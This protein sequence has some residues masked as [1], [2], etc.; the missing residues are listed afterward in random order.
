VIIATVGQSGGTDRLLIGRS[1]EWARARQALREGRSSVVFS[2]SPGVGKS[3]LAHA[4]ADDL[5]HREGAHCVAIFG[6]PAEPPIPFG[7]LAPLAG[8]IGVKP[9]RPPDPLHLM[10]TFRA[11]LLPLASGRPLVMIVDDAH[12]LD[13]HS[14]DLLLQLA[15]HDGVRI[16]AAIQSGHPV[17]A[18]VRSLW[19]EEIAE[20][21][22]VSPLDQES[23]AELVTSILTTKPGGPADPGQPTEI[24]V[25]GLTRTVGGEIPEAVWRL[26]QGNPLYTRE[27]LHTGRTSG[28]IVLRDG[29]WR[30]DRPLEVGER[31]A[32]L[33]EDRW[34]SH[35]GQAER[36][37]LE[38]I[39][40]ADVIPLRVLVR[41]VASEPAEVLQQQGLVAFRWPRD[42]QVAGCVHP[43]L[44][45]VVRRSVPPS[46]AAR[47]GLRLADAFE[48]DGQLEDELLRIVTWRM[49][50]GATLDPVVLA[51]AARQAAERQDWRGSARLAET[52]LHAGGG[53]EARLLLV[54]AHRA[55]GDFAVGLAVL[56]DERGDGDDLITRTAIL[57]G[58]LLYFGLGRLDEASDLLAMAGKEVHDPSAR[59]GL[60]AVDAG[61]QAFAGRPGQAVAR[62]TE[63]LR[64]P[65][66]DGWAEITARAALSLGLSWSGHTDRALEVLEAPQPR[67]DPPPYVDDWTSI[68]R[69][70][71][72]RLAGRMEPLERV[73]QQRYER[74][75]QAH[76]ILEQ[77]AAAASLGWVALE[78]ARLPRAVAWF[79]ESVAALRP[80]NT[81]ALRVHAL[82]G[83]SEAL[84]LTGETEGARL[85]LEEV[86]P[87]AERSAFVI[88]CWS[89][90]SAWLAAAQGAMSEAIELL[91]QA[92]DAARLSGQTAGEIRA[93]HAAARLGSDGPARRLAELAK[94]VDG[95]LI[96]VQAAHAAGLAAPSGGGESLDAVAERYAE[97]GL[98]LYAAE[99]AAQ[100]SRA[101]HGVGQSRRAAA[102]AARGHILLGPDT[103]RPV[104]LTLALSPPGLTRRE[105]EVAM[106]AAR[107]LPSQAIAT[108]LCLSVRTVETHLA[109]V[110]TKLGIGGR[111]ELAMALV[112]AASGREDVEAG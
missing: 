56:G 60:E 112:S 24:P 40:V 11:A 33:V 47:I 16:V 103:A 78:Q 20:W 48:S 30:L 69:S 67:S 94:W 8:G 50:A 63:L 32:E 77:G 52:A 61:L 73:A 29:V 7:S 44:R 85:A 42:E 79:R 66:T 3:A 35:L 75:V 12:W 23:T 108:R 27:L 38:L 110:Y 95:P 46:R 64:R 72:Y 96:G 98:H 93:L 15:V 39:A 57:R 10:Q 87:V 109:R 99:A 97:L 101:H 107:G 13:P 2:G 1:R 31:L 19:K 91:E 41:M 9:G 100:A 105:R 89:V 70:L 43:M 104:G 86:R 83:L 26:S 84:A 102:S 65:G 106:L 53:I 68:A 74:A 36:E 55:L 76:D 90:A 51:D 21:I 59:A 22:E 5:V 18:S 34:L 80:A 37:A 58:T 88:T 45:E 92:A 49:D 54:D 71:A 4:W 81:I 17:P 6:S 111:S 28:R 82:L 62:A 25:E 14:A